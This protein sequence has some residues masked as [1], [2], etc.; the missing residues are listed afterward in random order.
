LTQPTVMKNA[1][2]IVFFIAI[3]LICGNIIAQS[4][5]QLSAKR[6]SA[7]IKIDGVLDETVW[8]VAPVADS[9]VELRP[10]AFK[11]EDF[12]NRTEIWLLYNNEGI[13]IGGY[14][15]ETS[16]DSIA[17]ELVGRDNFGN[18]DFIGIIFD[19]YNDKINGFEYF[20][21]PL[22]EQMDAKQ[23]PNQNGNSEDFSWNAVWESKSTIV[24]DGWKFEMFIP[25]SAIR[26]SKKSKQ[27]WGLNIV[28]RRN[29]GGGQLF[30][31]PIDPQKNGFL[32]QEGFWT[33]IENIKPPL[34]LSFSP[35]FS[36]Y[37][38][39]Y[40]YN[41]PGV[42]NSTTSFNGGMDV[43][44]GISQAFTL[45]MT[46]IPD[47][48]QVQSDNKVL[49]LTPFE[50]QFNEN[51]S[52]FT[53][54]TE[55]FNKGDLF[56]SRRIGG[57][58]FHYYEV[59]GRLGNNE[60][61]VKNP[62]ESRLINA[63]KISGRTGKGLG[64]GAFNA[65]TKTQYAEVE[66]D[67][68]NS[69]KIENDPLTNYNVFVLDQTLK[70]N[71]SITL[72]NTNVIR[73]GQDY[74]A[75]V[76]AALFDFYDKHNKWNVSGRGYTST[77]FGI[78]G[79]NST[80]YKNIL[81]FGKVSG[82]FNFQLSQTIHDDKFDF[83]DLGYMTYN[84]YIERSAYLG[85]NFVKP[86]KIFNRLYHN[87]NFNLTHR[88]KPYGFQNISMNYN[89]NGQ[90]KNLWY[91]GAEL[92]YRPKGNDFYE[93]RI[94]DKVFRAPADLGGGFF[95]NSN[96]AKKYSLFGNVFVDFYSLEKGRE[97]NVRIGQQYRVN[98]K[99]SF[100]YN[101]NLNPQQNNI[102]YA[103]IASDSVIFARRNRLTIENI[104][105]VKYSFGNTSFITFRVR[106]YWSK[107]ENKQFYLLS[108]NGSLNKN[109][110]YSNNLNQNYNA[111]NIDMVYSWRFAPGSELNIVWKNSIGS[112][113]REISKGYFKN[114]NNTISSPQN[115]SVSLKVL[116]YID[117]LQLSKKHKSVL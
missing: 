33:G 39:N 97:L 117:Y 94:N 98:N 79:K 90:L 5:K 63:T 45:D 12:A 49:N 61:I 75:N 40:P 103:A 57:T 104:V 20:V 47:F 93:P 102:G 19:T 36:S 107:V 51:R 11:K 42:K 6:I 64:I 50:V 48:G 28:R 67:K 7:A 2:A 77:L 112:F 37:V 16:K 109:V 80:G 25:Y 73:N 69:R 10:V 78:N 70:N 72:I 66:D 30:W 59:E 38:N 81:S 13:Y 14:C 53:E 113:E 3:Y 111:F 89:F 27:D 99:L 29:K 58:P 105:R 1:F 62:S 35:Y 101:F 84:N 83:N 26:F 52:F 9:F 100:N 74:D 15:H 43:K 65:V 56:Y 87:L 96:R 91:V 8:K 24:N 76:T 41:T 44:Y 23:A 18:N 85:Y 92:N 46:L 106:H 32:T 86:K 82:K 22:G 108:T 21:T 116:Y 115:N 54:G 17:T 60:R 55:L 4:R 88:F 68:K 71:S 31:N 95:F 34:R 110:N 114:F